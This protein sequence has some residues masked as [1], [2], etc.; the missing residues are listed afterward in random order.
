MMRNWANRCVLC[1]VT[2]RSRGSLMPLAH[3]AGKFGDDAFPA[4]DL[5]DQG[6]E[7]HFGRGCIHFGQGRVFA[8]PAA[9]D[10]VGEGD[11]PCFVDQLYDDVFPEFL[12]G[13][14]FSGRGRVDGV[15]PLLELG[16]VSD[17]A[18]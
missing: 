9:E 1:T 10:A 13:S 15:R 3:W 2:R 17:A 8:G 11:L 5:E 6:F 14:A 16:V 4:V 7:D 18:L 12:E